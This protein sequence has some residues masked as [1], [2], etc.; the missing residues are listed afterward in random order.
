MESVQ[1]LL[2]LKH[3]EIVNKKLK[4]KSHK[5]KRSKIEVQQW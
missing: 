3:R 4:F 1:I 5:F 2:F